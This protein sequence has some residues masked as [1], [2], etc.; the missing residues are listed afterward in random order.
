MFS[1]TIALGWSSPTLPQLLASDSPLPIT[2]SEGSW[3]VSLIKVGAFLAIIP[4][5][6]LMNKLVFLSGNYMIVFI[7]VVVKLFNK[8]ELVENRLYCMVLFQQL[9]LGY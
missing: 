1:S 6:W 4:A 7:I 5:T 2:A 3:I 9:Y 8:T